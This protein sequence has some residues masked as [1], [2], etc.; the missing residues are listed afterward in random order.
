MGKST[1]NGPFSIAMLVYQRVPKF[2]T[3][4]A[5][6][7]SRGKNGFFG[8]EFFADGC[9]SPQIGVFSLTHPQH[10]EKKNANCLNCLH[11]A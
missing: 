2:F 9:S 1:I 3:A 5:G 7:G 10:P 8:G 6:A 11:I 4:L